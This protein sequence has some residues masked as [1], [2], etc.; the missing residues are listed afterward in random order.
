LTGS[1]VKK[2]LKNKKRVAPLVEALEPRM[3]YSA[4]FMG[5][6]A[7][8]DDSASSGRFFDTADLNAN[9]FADFDTTTPSPYPAADVDQQD[10]LLYLKPDS[11]LKSNRVELV[12]IDS[13]VTD[14]QQ[15]IDDLNADGDKNIL[16]HV[17]DGG[18]NGI[19]QIGEILSQYSDLDAVHLI[20]HGSDAGVQIGN[21]WLDADNIDDYGAALASWGDAMDGDADL[22]IYGCNLAAGQAG[23]LLLDN[24]SL[25][26]GADVAASDDL[27]GSADLGGDWDLEYQVGKLET[28]VVLSN[29]LQQ[30]WS[31]LL[32]TPNITLHIARNN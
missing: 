12:L 22:L 14:Y 18:S 1:N 27:T 10:D 5:V 21:T 4:D 20:S 11:E 6:F 28:N 16:V 23:Q 15:I 29:S 7:D 32:I 2:N 25:L 13:N 26:T 9:D 24:L 17:L 19:D 30:T 31:G 3:L 8:S